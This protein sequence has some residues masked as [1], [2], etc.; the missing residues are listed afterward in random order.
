M[1]EQPLLGLS[2]MTFSFSW[3]S[4]FFTRHVGNLWLTV[5]VCIYVSD[6]F[7]RQDYLIFARINTLDLSYNNTAT[8][9]S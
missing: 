7:L 9:L 5:Y 2:S 6:T 4:F 3:P 1:V 8:I